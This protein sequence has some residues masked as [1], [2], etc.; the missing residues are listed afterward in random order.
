MLEKDAPGGA[1]FTDVG[2]SG[3]G[4]PD[5]P[6]LFAIDVGRHDSSESAP[7]VH[8]T[9]YFHATA[10]GLTE[11]HPALGCGSGTGAMLSSLGKWPASGLAF[12]CEFDASYFRFAA[13]L[14]FDLDHHQIVLS[15][16][17]EQLSLAGEPDQLTAQAA[18]SASL[19]VY[20]D[21]EE[22]SHGTEI[23]LN[24][25]QRIRMVDAWTPVSLATKDGIAT[26]TYDPAKLWLQIEL[27]HSKYWIFSKE[28]F[29][30]I[31]LKAA[32]R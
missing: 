17:P 7:T 24:R 26:V 14:L 29:R 9:Y 30:A 27:N 21:H 20:R 32:A 22:S 16:P 6:Q 25:G 31:G 3:T 4:Y 11:F 15:P 18:A 13:R 5:H 23:Q 2:T 1:L 28:S 8:Y 10:S 12:A 19:R